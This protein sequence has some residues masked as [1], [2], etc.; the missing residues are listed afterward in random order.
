MTWLS[1]KCSV[2]S[3]CERE[4]HTSAK[5]LPRLENELKNRGDAAR[6]RAQQL[7]PSQLTVLVYLEYQSN[8]TDNKFCREAGAKDF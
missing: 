8:K 5:E 1:K 7:E 2:L 6:F 4:A 3:S